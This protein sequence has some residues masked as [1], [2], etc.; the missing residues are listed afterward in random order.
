MRPDNSGVGAGAR[1]PRRVE[2]G[3][4]GGQDAEVPRGAA[5]DISALTR[6][7]GTGCLGAADWSLMLHRVLPTVLRADPYR[8]RN[9][10]AAR[11]PGLPAA[12]E[13]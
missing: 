7:Q 8:P 13:L 1:P 5:N 2:N 9:I 12:G 11:P 3:T 10:R 4:Q 6:E